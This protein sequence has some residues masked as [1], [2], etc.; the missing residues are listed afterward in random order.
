MALTRF[1]SDHV[2]VIFYW[3]SDSYVFVDENNK[4]EKY[5][6][7]WDM[8]PDIKIMDSFAKIWL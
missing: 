1:I 7:H 6:I 8:D 2:L 5:Y 4:D 3:Q